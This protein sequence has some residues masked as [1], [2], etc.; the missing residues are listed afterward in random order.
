MKLIS[1]VAA[2]STLLLCYPVAAAQQPTVNASRSATASPIA[3]SQVPVQN[4]AVQTPATENP[5]A[6]LVQPPLQI[7]HHGTSPIPAGRL[8]R[9]LKNQFAGGQ[10]GPWQVITSDRKTRTLVVRRN[11]I[12]SENWSNWAYCKVGPLDMLDSLRDG[13]VTMAIKLE[14]A[15]GVTYTSTTADFEGIY[16]LTSTGGQ[17]IPCISRGVLEDQALA[18]IAAENPPPEPRRLAKHVTIHSKRHQ[19]HHPSRA[20]G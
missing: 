19:R 20:V 18:T 13:Y 1:T 4:A 8:Y 3:A 6:M 17:V 2:L 15:R 5:A 9:A 14:P 16:G 7:T 12:D 11:Y 10:L